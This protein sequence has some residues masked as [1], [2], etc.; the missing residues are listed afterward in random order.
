VPSPGAGPGAAAGSDDTGAATLGAFNAM[1]VTWVTPTDNHGSFVMSLN[2]SRHTARN[3]AS[4]GAGT[5][6]T[7]SPAAGGM[8]ALLLALGGCSGRP[9]SEGGLGRGKLAHC[10]LRLVAPGCRGGDAAAP[11]PALQQQRAPASSRK[12]KRGAGLGGSEEGGVCPP[13]PTPPAAAGAPAHLLC[14]VTQPLLLPHAGEGD[15]GAA[16]GAA[17]AAEGA[18]AVAEGVPRRGGHAL[19]LCRVESAWVEDAYWQAGKLFGVAAER[20]VEEGGGGAGGGSRNLGIGGGLSPSLPAPPPPPPP[21]L[22]CFAGS[23]VFVEMRL[24]QGTAAL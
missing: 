23:G 14:R 10:G 5:P 16:E 15:A 17:G 4:R 3:L 13:P 8:E 9:V 2:G 12:R 19:L 24:Q 20:R 7:L 1:T 21:P 22:L 11:A 18:A 6:F